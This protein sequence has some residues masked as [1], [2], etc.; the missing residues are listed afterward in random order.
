MSTR[1]RRVT[2][3][4][5][6][7]HL[8]NLSPQE[9]RDRFEAEGI[10]DYTLS[11]IRDYLNEA[12]AD[13]VIEQIEAEHANVRLQ[14]AERE[15]QLYQRAREAEAASV[16]DEPIKRV[17]PQ[18]T[19][20]PSDLDGPIRAAGWEELDPE[21]D[22]YPEWATERDVIIRFTDEPRDVMPGERR[23]IQGIDGEP[24]Y[25]TE[26]VGLRRDQPDLQGQAMA[27]QEQSKHLE[28]KGEALG[29]YS[30]DINMSVDAD[31]EHSVEL[32]AETA[33]AIREATLEDE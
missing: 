24:K 21:D 23:P 22:D 7:H 8:D 1:D 14:I 15:E 6:W 28:A 26:F 11:T 20:V 13:E 18:T 32:D 9:V 2:L 5:K 25:T 31:V 27:R 16:E 10:G 3:A 12:P 33:A 19:Q 29:V 30:T 4:L 17:V